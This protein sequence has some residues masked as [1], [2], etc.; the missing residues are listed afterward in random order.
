MAYRLPEE[1]KK[2]A[3]QK[4]ANN[5]NLEV[6]DPGTVWTSPSGIVFVFVVDKATGSPLWV[7]V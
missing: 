1:I 4:C 5:P 6:Q 2:R 7:V 3:E